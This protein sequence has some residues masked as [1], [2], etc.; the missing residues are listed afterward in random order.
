MLMNKIETQYFRISYFLERKIEQHVTTARLHPHHV[1]SHD[2]VTSH[3]HVMS[4]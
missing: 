3:Y 1:T 2:H 4:Q